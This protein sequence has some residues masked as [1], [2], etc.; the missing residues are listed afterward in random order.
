MADK[1]IDSSN[2]KQ[3]TICLCFID[4]ML[5]AY[6]YFIILHI[7]ESIGA[8]VLVGVLKDVLLRLNLPYIG[9][10]SWKK[11]FTNFVDFGMIM[12][13]FLLPFSIF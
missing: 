3:I 6:E 5:V 13:V 8:N 11:T 12:N 2:R 7:V 9:N 4:E 10:N 1:V